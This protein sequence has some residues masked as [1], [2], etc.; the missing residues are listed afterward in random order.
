M[1]TAAACLVFVGGLFWTSLFAQPSVVPVWP[2]GVLG[3]KHDPAY[4]QDTVYTESHAPRVQHVKDPTL[5]VYL[6]PP[7]K[8]L[9]AAVVICPG[10]GYIRLAIDHEGEEV[11]K[12]LNGMGIVGVVLTYRLP[13]DRIMT[14]KSIGPLQDVQEAIRIVRRRANEWSIDSRRIGVMGFSAGG[15]LAG[16]ASTLYGY[17][18]NPDADS[19]SAR[20]DFSLLIYG[21]ISMQNGLTHEGS[22]RS[23]L[24]EDPD[25]AL[26]NLFSA[27][28]QV[29]ARTPPAF[30]VHA[31][32]DSTVPVANSISYFNALRR[33]SI[34]VE[35]HLYETGGHGFGLARKGGTES[36]W[37]DACRNWLRAHGMV[38]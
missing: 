12:W 13:S 37:P 22:R 18:A 15:H 27:E 7:D 11:A 33:F 4:R 10:G 34:P 32:N 28:R 29:I 30:L 3:S 38:R 31:V 8:R 25:S 5:S 2:H 36:G 26:V 6:L 16:S 35:L 24:G 9:R 14:D 19:T 17:K 21:V 23:L 1:R 20:P